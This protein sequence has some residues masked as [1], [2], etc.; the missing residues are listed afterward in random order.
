M[1]EKQYILERDFFYKR[2]IMYADQF[3]FVA[4]TFLAH[5]IA[6]YYMMCFTSLTQV[7]GGSA[8]Y[9]IFQAVGLI[10][11][12][13]FLPFF[14]I[15]QY[16]RSRVPKLF[17]LADEPDSWKRKAIRWLSV[18]EILRGLIGV[19]PLSITGFGVMTSP[20]TYLLYTLFYIEP[21]GKFDAVLI[22]RKA[23]FVDILVF[24]L[25]YCAYFFL[26]DYLMYGKIKK[27]ILRHQQYLQGC[28]DEK[29]KYYNYN[30]RGNT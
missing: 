9:I 2:E 24:L 17:S 14:L 18:S 22:K 15:R 19:I 8:F 23:S 4:V 29:E 21:L 11:I 16:I 20:I 25:I 12:A 3:K 6:Y 7:W 26:Y 10:P 28:M 5:F 1:N 30:K 27:E 13:W